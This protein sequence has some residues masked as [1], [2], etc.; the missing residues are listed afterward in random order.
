MKN[1][2]ASAGVLYHIR[3]KKLM[4]KLGAGL[5]YQKGLVNPQGE[6]SYNNASSSYLNYQLLY[7]MEYSLS[8]RTSVF[9][10]PQ[11]VHS[12][13]ADEALREP[14]EIK[15]YRAGLGFGLLYHFH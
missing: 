11:F 1:G 2:G 5:Q 13:V 14:F 4:H 8:R 12:L 10:Q 6:Y 7:R 15:P 3:G 9:L